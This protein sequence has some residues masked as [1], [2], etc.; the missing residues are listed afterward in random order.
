MA[1][2]AFRRA[3][4]DKRFGVACAGELGSRGHVHR[5]A[6][7]QLEIQIQGRTNGSGQITADADDRIE[8]HLPRT[9]SNGVAALDRSRR[10]N[11]SVEARRRERRVDLGIESEGFQQC[12]FTGRMQDLGRYA[13][14]SFSSFCN[15]LNSVRP[16]NE[17]APQP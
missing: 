11:V 8:G 14:F 13:E 15:I 16:S 5:G 2:R 4:H 10:R 9:F 6:C 7:R 12:R 1:K 3:D 17:G